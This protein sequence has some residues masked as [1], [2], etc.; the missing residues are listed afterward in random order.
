MKES[1]D[2]A[3]ETISS[4]DAN[5]KRHPG[6]SVRR[7]MLTAL[8]LLP[9]TAALHAAQ[10]EYVDSLWRAGVAAYA[11]GDYAAAA[12]R[13]TA[14]E[15]LGLASPELY[16]NIADACFKQRKVAQSILYYE[17]ALKLDP[18]YKDAGYNLDIARQLTQDRID[19]VP[20]FFLRS[21]SRKLCYSLSSD[22]WSVLFLVLLAL[23]CALTVTFLLSS[24]PAQRRITFFSAI[25]AFLLAIPCIINA[26]WQKNDYEHRDSAIV[27]RPVCS[28]KSAPSGTNDLFILHEG[29][30][31][32]ILDTVGDWTNIALSD[33]REG[34]VLTSDITII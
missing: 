20:E 7:L 8:L 16:T 5:M 15:S 2:K 34:W 32:R 33:G 27:F 21:W 13:F 30:K 9:G 29:T 18:S 25:A 11:D 1:Y 23:G 28:A 26:S 3:A 12:D 17:R 22:V 6:A 14:I 31:V 19:S 10:T 24:G 4:L